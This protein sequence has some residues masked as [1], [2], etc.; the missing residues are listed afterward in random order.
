MTIHDKVSGITEKE[1][2]AETKVLIKEQ[3]HE[4]LKQHIVHYKYVK[5][6]NKKETRIVMLQNKTYQRLFDV[7]DDIIRMYEKEI[8][9]ITVNIKEEI[10]KMFDKTWNESKPMW[11]KI[12]QGK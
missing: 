3:L 10:L 5:N 12:S 8:G 7:T 4:I 1:M 2:L 9:E 11:L 6:L